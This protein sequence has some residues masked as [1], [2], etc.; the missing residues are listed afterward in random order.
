MVNQHMEPAWNEDDVCLYCKY[1][2][3]TVITVYCLYVLFIV[4]MYG[5]FVLMFIFCT[6]SRPMYCS[7]FVP[8]CLRFCSVI[9]VGKK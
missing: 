4:S 6:I 1:V 8:Y 7:L 5:L 9:Y 3:F 2:L